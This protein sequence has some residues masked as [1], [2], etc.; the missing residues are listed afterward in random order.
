[1]AKYLKKYNK[2]TQSWEII[3]PNSANDVYV[4]NPNFAISGTPITLDSALSNINSEINH[5]KRNVSWLAEHGGGGGYGGGGSATSNYGVVIMNAG[6]TNNTLYIRNKSIDIHFKFTGG[7]INDNVEYRVVYDGNYLT[8]YVKTR[9]NNVITIS[10][11]NIEKYTTLTPH[12]LIIEGIDADGMTIPS[13]TLSIVETSISVEC[14]SENIL[15]IGGNGVFNI[16]VTNKILNASTTITIINTNYGNKEYLYNY[17]STTIS[18]TQ[19]PIDFFKELVDV[20]N[21]AVG[22]IY[23]LTIKCQTTTSDGTVVNGESIST[24]IL[25]QG[26]DSLVIN[27]QGIRES[28]DTN[29]ELTNFTAG[30][31]CIFSF[32]PYL[33]NNNK[34][35]YAIRLQKKDGTY[36]INYAGFIDLLDE[37]GIEK[38]YS[39]NPYMDTGS[40]KTVS[41]FIPNQESYLGEWAIIIKCWSQNG[42]VVK[43]IICECEFVANNVSVFY[44]QIP[45]RNEN[46]DENGNTLFAAWDNENF[47]SSHSNQWV[48]HIVNY[49]APSRQEI[50]DG[51]VERQMNIYNTNGIENGL[52]FIPNYRLRLANEAYATINL[53]LT[54]DERGEICQNNGFTVSLVFKSDEHPYNNRTIFQWGQT[55]NETG[56]LVDGIKVDLEN[57]YWYIMTKGQQEKMTVKIQQNALTS[58]DF[59]YEHRIIINASNNEEKVGVA[60]IFVNGIINAAVE[61]NEYDSELANTMYLGCSYVK[62]AVT[63]FA[64]VDIMSVNIYTHYLNDIQVVVNAQNGIA[65]RDAQNIII[66]EKYDE[67]KKK[68]L[69]DESSNQPQSQLYRQNELGQYEYMCPSYAT[70]K[71]SNPPLPVLWLDGSQNSGFYQTTFETTSTDSTIT[72]IKYPNF[73]MMYYDPFANDGKGAEVTVSDNSMAVSIQGTSTTTL[74]SKNLEIYFTKKLDGYGDDRV[75][76]FQP[77]EDWFPES[78]F[79]L[80]ADVVDSAHANNTTLGR[81]INTVASKTILEDTP[82]MTMVKNNPP[83]DAVLKAMDNGSYQQE[84]YGE[85][86]NPPTVKHTL[87]GFQ[88]ILMVTFQGN[89]QPTMLGIYSFNLGRYSYFNMGLKFFKYF[90]R[91][92]YNVI[93]QEYEQYAAPA[94]IDY[95]DYYTT[96]ETIKDNKNHSKSINMNEIFSFE[97]GSDADDNTEAHNTWSQDDLSVIRR[98]GEFKF[99]GVNGNDTQPAT[100]ENVWKAL[101]RVF[102]A[103][104]IMP[105]SSDK[106]IVDS[107]GNFNK[108]NSSYASDLNVASELLTQRLSIK[109]CIAYFIIS[110]AFGMVDSLGKNLTLRTWD[111][112]YDDKVGDKENT[113]KWFPCF[114]DMDTAL[115]L[116]NAGAQTVPSTVYMDTYRNRN[117]GEGEI[118]SLE[119]IRNDGTQINRFGAYNA[120]L[121][122][123][124]RSTAANGDPSEFVRANKYVGKMYEETWRVLRDNNPLT[125]GPLSSP[126]KFIE[127]FTSQTVNCGELFFNQDYTIKYLTKNDKGVYGNLTM[128][129]GN[130]VEYI[131]KWLTDRF[132]YLDGVFE[133]NATIDS[134]IPY[135]TLGYITCGGPNN[136]GNIEFIVNTTSPVILKTEIGQNGNIVKY[137]LPP[138]TDTKLTL[139]TL[140]SDSKRLGINATTILTKID[141]LKDVRFQQFESMLLPKFSQLDLQGVETFGATNA[142][143]FAN[144]FIFYSDGEKVSDVRTI[145]LYNTKKSTNVTSFIVDVQNYKKLRKLNI[146]DSC[147][148]SLSLPTSPLDEF[149]F[150]GSNIAALEIKGQPYLSNLNFKGCSYIQQI[151]I[152]NCDNVTELTIPK[153][154]VLRSLQVYGCANLETLICNEQ[155]ILN[156]IEINNCQSLKRIVLS[157]NT[158][159]DLEIDISACGNIEEIILDATLSNNVRITTDSIQKVNYLSLS[160]CTNLQTFDFGDGNNL[161]FDGEKVM[162]LTPFVNLTSSNIHVEECYN[163]CY[164]KM[165]NDIEHP[166]P[167]RG[168]FFKQCVSLKRIF[169]HYGIESYTFTGCTSFKIHNVEDADGITPLPEIGAFED[170]EDGFNTNLSVNSAS[171]YGVFAKTKCDLHDVYYILQKCD[172]DGNI[173]KNKDGEIKYQNTINVTSLTNTFRECKLTN[174]NIRNNFHRETFKHCQNVAYLENLFYGSIANKHI[175]YSPKI[176]NGEIVEPGL[177]SYLGKV[178]KISNSFPNILIDDNCFYKP[179]NGKA[180]DSLTAI[181]YFSPI[182]IEDTNTQVYTGNSTPTTSQATAFYQANRGYM[183]SSVFFR[184]M[185]KLSNIEYAFQSIWLNFE[186]CNKTNRSGQTTYEECLFYYTPSI[187]V[188]KSAFTDLTAYGRIENFFGGYK[189]T[190]DDTY[191]FPQ[192]LTTI[193]N[194]F[195]V[196]TVP[197]GKSMVMLI[198]NSFFAKIKNTI[199]Y[200]CGNPTVDNDS[201]PSGCFSGKIS[202]YID[203]ENETKLVFPYKIFNG[204]YQLK[205][206]TS[207]FKGIAR[208]SDGV[209]YSNDIATLPNYLNDSNEKVSMFKDCTL[210]T[211]IAYLFNSMVNIK[212]ELNGFGFENCQL[213]NVSYCFADNDNTETF[214][215]QGMI[216]YGLFFQKLDNQ[217]YQGKNGLTKS[218][219]DKLGITTSYGIINPSINANGVVSKNVV[220]DT[221]KTP[222]KYGFYPILSGGT[223]AD[224]QTYVNPKDNSSPINMLYEF[225]EY[226]LPT[227]ISATTYYN[228]QS[229]EHITFQGTYNFYKTT[230]ETMEG[231]FYNSKGTEFQSYSISVDEDKISSA[232]TE[233]L[234]DNELYDPIYLIPN[235]EY[236]PIL[237]FPYQNEIGD[238]M[239]EQNPNYDPRRYVLNPS[240]NPYKKKWNKWISDGSTTLYNMIRE[241]EFY[242]NLADDTDLVDKNS[243]SIISG[244]TQDIPIDGVLPND[245][246]SAIKTRFRDRNYM[247]APDLLRYCNNISSLNI[248]SMFANCGVQYYEGKSGGEYGLFINKGPYG[249]LPPFMF[250]T[251]SLVED[252]TQFF[253][254]CNGILPYQWGDET[255]TGLMFDENLFKPLVKLKNL[256]QCFCNLLMYKKVLLPNNLFFYNTALE[257]LEGCF[258]GA[259]WDDRDNN[260]Q[261]PSGLFANNKKIISVKGMFQCVRDA[262]AT[263]PRWMNKDLFTTQHKN[264]QDVTNFLSYSSVTKGSVPEFWNI[265][266]QPKK[267]ANCYIGLKK[268]NINNY[269]NI[270][271]TYGGGK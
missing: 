194:A 136:G 67:W 238:I 261:L 49:V 245:I 133:V 118:N 108:T 201:T 216:P 28:G 97:F 96:T 19:I 180:F 120:K 196:T 140:S 68:N 111:A 102:Y 202:K 7:T 43:Q 31:N 193:R 212:Y 254:S 266:P 166:I 127:M 17:T 260:A 188:I 267:Y 220:F 229:N 146:Q 262:S 248:K 62:N 10:I 255:K 36:A 1:M 240:Y 206:V 78:Q 219:A 154:P 2:N 106:Y 178:V 117:V 110:N 125:E 63:N 73:N 213:K 66:Q 170:N 81:W 149:I 173:M 29:T 92:R 87:E 109:N 135:Y 243:L 191:H 164:L 172:T 251:V 114:Y 145:N 231:L 33:L 195:T 246:S 20:T 165:A 138:Y 9:V 209:D 222:N 121:W 95:Y 214:N 99:N 126:S 215:L 70:L 236:N 181:T 152:D 234:I 50:I 161:T 197:S 25:I 144:T 128:L 237:Y 142:I 42:K 59:V 239:Y 184:Y 151:K 52:L 218:M 71:G 75:Q 32:T 93:S 253:N 40:M 176:A 158:N 55:S 205:E 129:H 162:D 100:N 148:T 74:R 112:Y 41:Y 230:I 98:I 228:I 22:N 86:N 187:R 123:I 34:T 53:G 221:T 105:P 265:Q 159:T 156:T 177:F 3:S 130:R 45:K 61:V 47:P 131:R 94:L 189:E 82:P 199:E 150:D 4:T 235:S 249:V 13:Y 101:Q 155:E 250:E 211:N 224:G 72:K 271:I 30:G 132:I 12:T 103:S 21:V 223:L 232:N 48:S 122:N 89:T 18:K 51:G 225:D 6:V 79:T 90:S 57:V 64:D 16:F 179:L 217:Q 252:L 153:L 186:N 65:E 226:G 147:V 257:T 233:I 35:Y 256:N 24:R 143:D 227:Q 268:E 247:F 139:P 163:L 76:M 182:F 241:S 88:I 58:L 175:V 85:H 174:L 124:L 56:E 15:S 259:W 77:K 39:D 269:D 141:G 113:N 160:A 8:Q 185:P 134:A 167:L 60:K 207:L 204:C 84:S 171:L 69:F 192:R 258:N 80:K 270:P 26:T 38:L 44:K 137:Y 5:L 244:V 104:A 91:R 116:T 190:I 169:G 46:V 168:N 198:G 242:R 27:V 264:L 54:K 115:G 183:R 208:V 263:A 119:I 203:K 157:G 23:N 200:F 14:Q 11:D 83:L 107:A 37:N 210:L